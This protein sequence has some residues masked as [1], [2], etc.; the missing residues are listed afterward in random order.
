[1]DF[2]IVIPA[3]ETN[4]YHKF[5]DLAPFGDT[6]LLEW[7]IA[8]CKE[9]G[10]SSQIYISSDSEKIEEIA[11]K[12]GVNFRKRNQDLKYIEIIFETLKNIN[13][14]DIIWINP[15]SPF[16]SSQ[17]YSD[18]YTKYKCESLNSLV[19]VEKK[20]EYIFFNNKKLNFQDNF[21]SRSDI[22][23][24]YIMTNGCSIIKKN[25]A[26][27]NSNLISLNPSFFEVDSFLSTEIKDV[28]DYSIALEMIS[29]YFKKEFDV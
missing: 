24:I 21:I 11:Q 15:T 29:I 14:E 7:K 18:M 5:G 8:Q 26:L 23:P 2:A 25:I 28:H 20:K 17:V 9:F 22:E 16:M 27:E 4:K 3:Q 12:E 1:M 6:T 13:A 10:K 19:S